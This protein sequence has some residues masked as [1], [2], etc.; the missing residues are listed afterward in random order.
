M[1]PST[2]RTLAPIGLNAH[3]MKYNGAAI[4]LALQCDARTSG[5][6]TTHKRCKSEPMTEIHSQEKGSGDG[7]TR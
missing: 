7:D 5:L 6:R 4:D 1:V 3:I 2:L